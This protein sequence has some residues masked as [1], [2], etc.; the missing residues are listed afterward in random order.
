MAIVV[1]NIDT[2]KKNF[3]VEIDGKKVSDVN[4]VSCYQYSFDNSK[5]KH[6][7]LVVE[8]ANK[9]ENG[10]I[11]KVSYY[12]SSHSQYND[13]S[14]CGNCV[15]DNNLPSFVGKINTNNVALDIAKYFGVLEK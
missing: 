14:A 9:D 7:E 10:I 2:D 6:L 12:S 15:Y 8:V 5:D 3:I 1:I 11:K 4:G 13:I